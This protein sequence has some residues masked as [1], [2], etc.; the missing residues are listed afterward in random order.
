ML[1][2][3]GILN[4]YLVFCVLHFYSVKLTLS[5][6]F[7]DDHITRYMEQMMLQEVLM[8]LNVGVGQLE[9]IFISIVLYYFSVI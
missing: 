6:V 5:V 9:D 4:D 3:F 8:R 1:E 2:V 7:G